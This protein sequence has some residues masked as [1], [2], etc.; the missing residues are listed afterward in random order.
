MIADRILSECIN[1]MGF[2]ITL[3]N[4]SNHYCFHRNVYW[5]VC[6]EYGISTTKMGDACGGRNHATVINGL[7]I[8]NDVL[9]DKPEWMDLY[10]TCL[11]RCKKKVRVMAHE[12]PKFHKITEL[13][14]E[15]KSL[16]AKNRRLERKMEKIKKILS[17]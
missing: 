2:D 3:K 17:V 5:A 13:R 7:K 9:S 8:F 12:K 6:R 14:K 15:V 10:N 11:N 1:E 4:R 16:K